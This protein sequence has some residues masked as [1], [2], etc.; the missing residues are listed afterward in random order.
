MLHINGSNQNWYAPI[1]KIEKASDNE[2]PLKKIEKRIE[3]KTSECSATISK[4][5]SFNPLDEAPS[6][7]FKDDALAKMDLFI[8]AFNK[9]DLEKNILK[10]WKIVAITLDR[11]ALI[12]FTLTYILTIIG[13]FSLSPGYAP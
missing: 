1:V 11:C 4:R 6:N 9:E 5:N 3:K 7:F 10:E 8:Q 2:N 12:G 13:C